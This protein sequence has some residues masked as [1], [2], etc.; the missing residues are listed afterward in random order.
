[1]LGLLRTCLAFLFR[2]Y[3]LPAL[4]PPPPPL[5]MSSCLVVIQTHS[6]P[7]PHLLSSFFS[8]CFCSA[9]I[10]L[11]FFSGFSSPTIPKCF[12][13]LFVHSCWTRGFDCWDHHSC[14]N[15][16]THKR[17]YC[18]GRCPTGALSLQQAV[19]S[20]NFPSSTQQLNSLAM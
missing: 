13:W 1:M 5:A 8:S 14:G 19:H 7:F 6:Q 2:F 4:P 11:R 20:S 15:F 3:F 9:F 10:L 12:A 18:A 17:A 16:S